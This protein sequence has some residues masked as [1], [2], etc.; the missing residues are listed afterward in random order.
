MPRGFLNR[1]ITMD[2][3]EV[4]IRKP[5]PAIYELTRTKLDLPHEAIFFLDDLG[6]NLKPARA[7][8]WQTLRYDDTERVLAVLDAIATSRPPRARS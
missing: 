7:L 5:E 3:S 4:G 6:V 8:G 2:S 1:M